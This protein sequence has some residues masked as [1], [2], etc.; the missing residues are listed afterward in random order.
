MSPTKLKAGFINILILGGAKVI[1][2]GWGRTNYFNQSR[3][4]FLQALNTTIIDWDRCKKAWPIKLHS[5]H[6][7]AGLSVQNKTICRVDMFM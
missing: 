7:C 4:E 3:P 5:H 6:I 2:A 1:V